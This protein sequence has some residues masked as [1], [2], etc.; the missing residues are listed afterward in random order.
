MVVKKPVATKSAK[1]TPPK[2]LKPK[3]TGVSGAPKPAPEKPVKA[4]VVFV[5]RKE[6]VERIVASSGL[7]PNAVKSVLDAV[8]EEIGNTL[9]GGEGLNVQPLGKVSVNRKKLFVDKEI[10]I[11]KIRRKVGQTE[12]PTGFSTAAE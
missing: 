11:C 2:T 3:A 9:S 1:K 6:L 7:K 4:P 10:I 12:S 8:L 5:R